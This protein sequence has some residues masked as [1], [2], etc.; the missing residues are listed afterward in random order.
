MTPKHNA[1]ES[2]SCRSV[3]QL[4]GAN[5]ALHAPW[6][7]HTDCADEDGI[8]TGISQDFHIARMLNAVAGHDR[9]IDAKLAGFENALDRVR[10]TSRTR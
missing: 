2:F 8:S 9:D 3:D 1:S 10:Q 7:H 5:D 4:R 6:P